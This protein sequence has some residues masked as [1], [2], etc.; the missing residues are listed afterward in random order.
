MKKMNTP[1]ELPAGILKLSDVDLAELEGKNTAVARILETR[2]VRQAL[3]SILPDVF[4]VIAGDSRFK[5]A[6]MK[7]V[8]R[9]LNKSLSRPQDIFEAE[10]LAP[11]FDDPQFVK[12]LAGPMPELINGSLT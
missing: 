5:R 1:S 6:I 7:M 8:G 9:F 11:L 4:N 3:A 10:E 12:H 2:E